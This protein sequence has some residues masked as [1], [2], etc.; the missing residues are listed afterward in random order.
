MVNKTIKGIPVQEWKGR[1][2]YNRFIHWSFQLYI[3]FHFLIIIV[4]I[5]V[6]IMP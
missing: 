1:L 4:I 5:I 3:N 2:I 6:I